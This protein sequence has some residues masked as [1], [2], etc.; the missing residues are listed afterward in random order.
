MY[1]SFHSVLETNFLWKKFPVLF[2]SLYYGLGILFY[3]HPFLAIL[4]FV[5]LSLVWIQSS[6]KVR[7]KYALISIFIMLL[8]IVLTHWKVHSQKRL[9]SLYVDLQ[10]YILLPLKNKLFSLDLV[11]SIAALFDLF[12]LP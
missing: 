2:I 6:S 1:L 9:N 8:G 12:R 4:I 5:I 3:F 11:M 10:L 7:Y